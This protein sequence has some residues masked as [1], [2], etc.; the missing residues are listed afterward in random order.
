[1]QSTFLSR[2]FLTLVA[3]QSMLLAALALGA[4]V[5]ALRVYGPGAHARTIALFSLV[6]IQLGHTF[7]CR[8]RSRTVFDGLFRNPFLWIAVAVVVL[9][10]L[11][12][13]YFPPLAAILGTTQP[14]TTDWLVIC[15]CGFLI[16]GIVEVTKFAQR[17]RKTSQPSS[18]RR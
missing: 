16:V 17:L 12:A 6:A 14:S 5:W 10:Q 15:G 11:L 8:S 9:L 7:N 2:P 3:W 4:Y 1:M 13:V 18:N